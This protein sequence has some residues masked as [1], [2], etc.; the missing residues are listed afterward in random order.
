MGAGNAISVQGGSVALRMT[1]I[2]GACEPKV[3]AHIWFY[4]YPSFL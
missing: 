4:H 1:N 2:V 3:M